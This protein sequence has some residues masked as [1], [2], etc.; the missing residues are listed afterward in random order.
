MRKKEGKRCQCKGGRKGR[1]E[2]G[3]KGQTERREGEKGKR[4]WR[5]EDWN[6]FGKVNIFAS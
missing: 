2:V 5:W 3:G 1:R 4:E 6:G